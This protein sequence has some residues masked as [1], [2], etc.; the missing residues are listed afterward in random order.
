MAA[1]A[2]APLSEEVLNRVCQWLK[3]SRS[4]LFITGAGISADSGLPTYRGIGGLYNQPTTD[5][6]ISIEEAISGEMLQ[7]H[8]E[9]TWKYIA[10]IER[11]C[12][13][14]AGNRAHA[15][16]AEMEEVF[17]RVCVLTQNIDGFHQA[18]G[19]KN[20]IDIHGDIHDVK[21]LRCA[22][23][24]RVADYSAWN[25]LPPHC[26]QCRGVLRPEVVLFGEM[27]PAEKLLRL[28]RA[29]ERGFDLVFSVGTTS[30]FPYIA[31]PVIE[32]KRRGIPTVE[33]NP[34]RTSVSDQVE[35]KITGR[36]AAT[37]EQIWSH[38]HGKS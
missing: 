37:L 8:P 10:Q 3:K 31:R 21:C 19:S 38:Y 26:P 1:A 24:A 30:V 14:A 7:A 23:R 20:V 27:L 13:A 6:G 16:I 25:E 4:L 12:R 11:A 29:W 28:E 18:A 2:S 35:L 32:A 34:G 22:Y 17:E 33:I 15:V 9:V 5:E 36:A